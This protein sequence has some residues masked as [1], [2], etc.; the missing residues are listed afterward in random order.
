MRLLLPLLIVMC[1]GCTHFAQDSWTGKDKAQHV[2]GSALL[3][4]AGSE[5]G[6]AQH[7]SRAQSRQFGLMF[8]FTLGTGKE[9]FDSRRAGSGWSWKDLSWDI[10]GAAT[11]YSLWNAAHH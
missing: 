8:A 10:A 3:T 9:L 6:A 1:S 5:Y 4:I 2:V 11:G 7:W